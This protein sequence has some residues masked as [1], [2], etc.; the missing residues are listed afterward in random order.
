MQ[1]IK[2][3]QSIE[4]VRLNIDRID[5]QIVAL[6]TERGAYVKQAAQFKASSEDV[7]APHRVEQVISKVTRLSKE[8]GGQPEIV[9][10]VYRE[11][12]AGFINAEMA[13]H[14]SILE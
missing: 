2:T 12:V 3:C 14:K 6:I 13:E 8:L 5:R 7:K 1:K 11:M 10:K 9:E 4:D